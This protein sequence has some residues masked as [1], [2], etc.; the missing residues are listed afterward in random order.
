MNT[1]PFDRVN[2]GY[3]GLFGPRTMFYHL[4]PISHGKPLVENLKVPVLDLMR[5]N[6]VDGGTVGVVFLGFLW[7]CWRLLGVIV[8]DTG[9]ETKKETRKKDQ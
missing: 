1:N 8:K 6:W 5:A 3:D 7:V 2:L 4:Q 9:W